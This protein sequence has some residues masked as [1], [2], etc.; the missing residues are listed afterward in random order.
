MGFIR[1]QQVRLALRLLTWKYQRN[2]L[3]LPESGVLRKTAC[4][5]VDEAHRIAG[6]RGRNVV[7]I[8]KELV[9][10]LKNKP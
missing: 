8:V 2:G 3:P 1:D 9:N 5:V 10:D 7:S 6:A 4:Q